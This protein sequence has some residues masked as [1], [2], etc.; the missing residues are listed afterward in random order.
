VL[1][2][3]VLDRN[4]GRS[5]QRDQHRLVLGVEL[6]ATA[7]LGQVQV[8]VDLVA[9]PDRHGK[10]RLHGRM[11]R[12]EAEGLAMPGDIGQAKWLGIGDQ[13]SEQALALRPVVDGR[14]L[15]GADS[16]RYEVASLRPSLITP[17]APYCA[18]TSDTA[19][20]RQNPWPAPERDESPV[21]W[22][23]PALTG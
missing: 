7:L 4:S 3:R 17:T 20:G 18:S 1:G 21:W 15:F 22:R 9:D 19:A 2:E 8:S 5:R 6:T 12:R 13:Q 16:D 10:K 23:R 14:D 11:A